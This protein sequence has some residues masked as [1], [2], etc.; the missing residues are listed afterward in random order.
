FG[1]GPTSRPRGT[2]FTVADGVVAAAGGV[3]DT[4]GRAFAGGGDR[5]GHRLSGG[6]VRPIGAVLSIGTCGALRTCGPLW[7]CRPG[8]AFRAPRPL[9]GL[10]R[11]G[12]LAA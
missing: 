8:R 1:Q 12:R 5:T 9:L 7:T 6:A 11:G 4:S 2:V 10:G 3:F